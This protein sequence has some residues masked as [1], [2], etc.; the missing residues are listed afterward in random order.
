MEGEL[1]VDGNWVGPTSATVGALP[2]EP[3]RQTATKDAGDAKVKTSRAMPE[4]IRAAPK[5]FFGFN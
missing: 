1:V 3:G 2:H 5:P 4:S